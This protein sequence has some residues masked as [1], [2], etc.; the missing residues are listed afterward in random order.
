MSAADRQTFPTADEGVNRVLD[1]LLPGLMGALGENLTAL[2][3]FGS[4]VWGDFDAHI[5]DI[6]LLCVT[7]RMIDENQF[8]GLDRLHQG[9]ITRHPRF[10]DRLE[11][12]YLSLEG[13]GSIR[14]QSSRIAVISPGEPFHFKEAGRD[15]LLNLYIIQEKGRSLYGL[16][17]GQLIPPI[18][19]VEFLEQVRLQAEEWRAWII[20]TRSSRPY[21]GYAILT[22][23]RALYAVKNGEQVSKRQAAEWVMA[24][25]PQYAGAVREALGWRSGYRE[26]VADPESTYPATEKLVRELIDRVWAD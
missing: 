6:D 12:A 10:E 9:L 23:C 4:L 1:E 21:Q 13:M 19:K 16:P 8:T 25:Y 24:T 2:Y 18:S 11:I 3:L 22:M 15:W 20:H 5:S 26:T 14:K 7:A 17:P